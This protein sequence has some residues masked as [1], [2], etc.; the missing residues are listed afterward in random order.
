MTILG[1]ISFSLEMAILNRDSVDYPYFHKMI[2]ALLVSNTAFSEYDGYRQLMKQKRSICYKLS[3]GTTLTVDSTND[4]V[5]V[6]EDYFDDYDDDV[7]NQNSK[8]R[9]NNEATENS[10]EIATETIVFEIVYGVQKKET[11]IPQ[12]AVVVSRAVSGRDGNHSVK[13]G[14]DLDILSDTVLVPVSSRQSPGDTSAQAGAQ[15]CEELEAENKKRHILQQK[16]DKE[17]KKHGTD[18]LSRAR[19]ALKRLGINEGALANRVFVLAAVV[20]ATAMHGGGKVERV[21][22]V[23]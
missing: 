22:A 6:L 10:V 3:S 11:W 1:S 5:Q 2:D 18:P 12:P 7:V 16:I 9:N 15:Q 19:Y 14:N 17:V 20:A 23:R 8:Q 13:G 21:V 4:L